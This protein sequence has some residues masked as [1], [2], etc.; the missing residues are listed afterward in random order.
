MY[1]LKSVFNVL[2]TV[3]IVPRRSVAVFL[4]CNASAAA[5]HLRA[6]D[7]F[8]VSDVYQDHAIDKLCSNC[9]IAVKVS[10]DGMSLLE[11]IARDL[12][13]SGMTPVLAIERALKA[14]LNERFAGAFSDILVKPPKVKFHA[15]YFKH[16]Y[17]SLPVLLGSEYET[18]YLEITLP[19]ATSHAFDQIELT[20]EAL[21]LLP[22][23]YRGGVSKVHQ[24]KRKDLKM[25]TNHTVQ[26]NHIKLGSEVIEAV[27]SRFVHYRFSD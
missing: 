4:C 25:Q 18:W 9:E 14:L 10:L 3:L 2:V 26:V 22:I 6:I 11:S 8:L 23:V 19:T 17:A 20:S 1:A 15:M 13:A 24:L 27:L 16:R 7:L 12:S 21:E 5:F